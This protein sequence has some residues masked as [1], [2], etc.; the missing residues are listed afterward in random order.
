MATLERLGAR[1]Q[2]TAERG[3]PPDTDVVHTVNFATPETTRAFAEDA[4]RAGAP[5]VVTTL[6]EDWR[7]SRRRRWRSRNCSP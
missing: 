2:F 4:V 1:V 7:A 5:L 3:V 6:Y